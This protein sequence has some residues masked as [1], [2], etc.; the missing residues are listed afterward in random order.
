MSGIELASLILGAVPVLVTAVDLSRSGYQ[1]STIPF[2]KRRYVGMLTNALLLQRQ[3][4]A[5]TTRLLVV[6]SGCLC[7]DHALQT[8]LDDDLSGYLEDENVREQILDF[9][10]E[11]NHAALT[12]SLQEIHIILKRVAKQLSGIVPAS[13][14]RLIS[15][16]FLV[17]Y[18][19]RMLINA[20]VGSTRRS[21]RNNRGKPGRQKAASRRDV[22]RKAHA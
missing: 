1:K 4:V 7:N 11:K 10:G 16:P 5:E 17:L 22:A 9:L 18:R 3:T 19:P 13:Q 8:Q 21:P 14:V 2:R 12:G 6:H 15:F 20:C